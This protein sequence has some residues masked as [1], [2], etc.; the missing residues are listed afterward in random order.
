MGSHITKLLWFVT[1]YYLLLEIANMQ[2]RFG[3]A[4]GDFYNMYV[5][6][7]SSFPWLDDE[8]AIKNLLSAC[9]NVARFILVISLACAL[10]FSINKWNF[11]PLKFYWSYILAAIVNFGF[12]GYLLIFACACSPEIWTVQHNSDV[13]TLVY[14]DLGMPLTYFQVMLRPLIMFVLGGILLIVAAFRTKKVSL[15]QTREKVE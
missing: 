6:S 5:F 10:S 13:L 3:E 12:V 8:Y 7:D 9:V 11:K 1:A 4:F 15:P 14:N 2:L